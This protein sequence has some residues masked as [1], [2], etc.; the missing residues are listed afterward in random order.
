MGTFLYCIL[1]NMGGSAAA[2]SSTEY[3]LFARTD[4]PSTVYAFTYSP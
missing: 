3:L 4:A 2:V 1:L